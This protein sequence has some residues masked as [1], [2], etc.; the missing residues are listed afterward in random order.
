[1]HLFELTRALIDIESITENEERVGNFLFDQLS[2]LAA[3]F[4]GQVERIP[5]T[6]HRFNVAAYFGY[7]ELGESAID[8]LLEALTEI[9]RIQ[10]PTDG[11][12]GASTLNI[13]KLSGGRAPNVIADRACAELMIRLVDDGQTTRVALARAVQGKAE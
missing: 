11:T 4:D 10:L 13:G 9:R 12:L 6:E 7:P 8:K 5:V 3:R 2:G 1:M